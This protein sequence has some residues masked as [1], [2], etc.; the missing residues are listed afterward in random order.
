MGNGL[1]SCFSPSVIAIAS[2]FPPGPLE[3]EQEGDGQLI[4]ALWW[5]KPVFANVRV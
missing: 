1:T 3:R 4:W 5:P 2:S